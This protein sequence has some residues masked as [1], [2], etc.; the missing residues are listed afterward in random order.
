MRLEAS[1]LQVS[2][3]RARRDDRGCMPA[4]SRLGTSRR[5]IDTLIKGTYTMHLYNYVSASKRPGICELETHNSA[6]GANIYTEQ[7]I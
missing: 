4:N 6:K 5:Y 1:P 3:G 7:D 2:L